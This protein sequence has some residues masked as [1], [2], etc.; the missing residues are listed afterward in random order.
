[1]WLHRVHLPRAGHRTNPHGF[2]QLF[3]TFLYVFMV[4]CSDEYVYAF[5]S[6]ICSQN[7]GDILDNFLA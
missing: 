1:V 6:V 5:C 3:T 4:F 2:D 7:Y